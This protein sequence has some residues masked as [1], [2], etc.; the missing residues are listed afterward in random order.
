MV[1]VGLG[2]LALVGC[3]RANEQDCERIIDRIVQL[4]LEEQGITDPKVIEKR[5][6]ETRDQKRE[7]L[8]EGCVGKR[9]SESALA[10]IDNAKTSKEIT[11]K[12]L[13]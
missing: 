4:E 1:F 6:R 12:C 11:E 9:I 5:K 8:L 2:T 3:R 13:R 7:E 10:C